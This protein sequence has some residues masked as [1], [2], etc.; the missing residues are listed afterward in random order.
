[1]ITSPKAVQP[2]TTPRGCLLGTYAAL[3]ILFSI[4][5]ARTEPGPPTTVVAQ[6]TFNSA[7]PDASSTTGNL[8]ASIGTGAASAVGTATQTFGTIGTSPD[9]GPDNSSWRLASFP[10]QYV[11]PRTSGAQFVMDASL[12][13]NL[14]MTWFQRNSDSASRYWRLQTS[15]N[16]IDFVDHS[17]IVS[18]PNIWQAFSADFSLVPGANHNPSFAV[19]LVSDFQRPAVALGG[20]GYSAANGSSAYGS[21]GTLWL[22]LVTVTGEASDPANKPPSISL[23]GLSEPAITT[24]IDTASAPFAVRISDLETPAEQLQVEASSSHPDLIELVE[25]QGT[26]AQREV[27]IWPALDRTGQ[28]EI[29]LVVID[30]TGQRAAV[31]LGCVVIPAQTPPV[32]KVAGSPN[33]FTFDWTHPPEPILFTV[34]DLESAP[35]EVHV[36]ID[37]D[38]KVF[39]PHSVVLSGTGSERRLVLPSTGRKAGAGLVTLTATDP[40]GLSSQLELLVK[41][42][43][44]DVISAWDYNSPNADGSPGTGSV[45]AVGRLAF[46]FP[47]RANFVGFSDGFGST[48]PNE[49]D[50]S[51]ARLSGFAAQGQSN[52][53]TGVEI[54]ADTTGFENIVLFWDQRNS[55]S[56]SRYQRVQFS[57]DFGAS[58]VDGPLLE[59]SDSNWHRQLSV[60]LTSLPQAANHPGLGIRIVNEFI[61]TALGAGPDSYVATRNTSSYSPNGTQRYD[62]IQLHG[63]VMQPRL[64]AEIHSSGT[65]LRLTWRIT[66]E[67]YTLESALFPGSASW[68]PVVA[69]LETV[70][71]QW[72]ALVP[73]DAEQRYF[74]LRP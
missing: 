45:S 14:H 69:A 12:G 32:L 66:A 11:G 13:Q 20:F 21:S 37:A 72:Q 6:W 19:R 44:R 34:R 35:E 61:S 17:V 26:G 39:P 64:N 36:T 51:D 53:L 60:D 8:S 9:P 56:A 33:L 22:D 4:H 50:N 23:A 29:T 65:E 57:Y 5:G 48:D 7:E 42:S 74:R 18:T 55:D 16:G 73:I 38:A 40:D 25:I 31:R 67:T 63:E 49:T 2:L 10:P 70:G 68:D 28:T 52:K 62:M 27:I 1:M 41:F 43:P 30:E 47:T 3:I 46:T 54:R 59:F 24:R 58:W 15:T 71:D